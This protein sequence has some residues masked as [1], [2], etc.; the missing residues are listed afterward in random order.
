MKNIIG[1]P[2]VIVLLIF[3]VCCLSAQV[4]IKKFNWQDAGFK[5]SKP[6]YTQTINIL[7]TGGVNN[8]TGSNNQAFAAAVTQLNNKGG[9]IYFPPGVYNFTSSIVFTR[10]SIT[11]VGAG[12]QLTHFRFNLGSSL[13]PC[14]NISGS[15]VA[16]DTTSFL[17][18]GVRD[19]ASVQVINAAA[20]N[21]GQW[22]YLQC[23]DNAYMA[24]TWAYGS[25][26]QIMQIKSKSG[27][28]L[29]FQ[30][31]FRFYYKKSLQPKIKKINPRKAVGMECFSIQRMQATTGQSSLISFDRAA[32]CWIHAI[33]G[34]ST[35]F[36][37][38][39]INRSAN[40]SITN[41]YFHHAYAY[42]GGGQAY[43]V[44]FQYSASECLVENNIFRNLRHSVL[45]QAGANGNVCGYNY[46]FDP[47]WVQSFFPTN[48]AGDIV[49]HGNYPF[50]NLCEGNINQNTVIDDSHAK[51]GPYN[52]FFRNRS[53]LYGLFMNTNPATDTC[54]FIGLEITNPGA[55]L[56]LY[57]LA[58]NGHLQYAN[59]VKGSIT[60]AN[61]SNLQE[62][63]LYLVAPKKPACFNATKHFWPIFGAPQPYNQN[64]NAAKD[65]ATQAVWADC[66]QCTFVNTTGVMQP[67]N[68]SEAFFIYPNPTQDRIKIKETL[69]NASFVIYTTDGSLIFSGNKEETENYSKHLNP[70]MYLIKYTNNENTGNIKLIKH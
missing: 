44:V 31:P 14:M 49:M 11:V 51:N 36:A 22:V 34:D 58:G 55:T 40:I 17:N 9:V 52:T 25:L 29:R 5:G 20:F 63:S 69:N 48:S 38:V 32:Q 59:N 13:S 64:T 67:T 12:Y 24:S 66:S 28:N 19:S 37:H 46:S 57:S 62:T 26:G 23:N 65:R 42:G 6:V 39:E 18:A 4:T 15:E 56:G 7:N 54:Q 45:F 1:K 70:G 30:S 35:N 3:A 2:S 10:D 50:A 21:V 53:E 47:Y 16:A 33:E 43:G 8:G 68:H 41:S 27:N 60:P 61:T